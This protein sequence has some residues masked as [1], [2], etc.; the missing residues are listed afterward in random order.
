[1]KRKK[2]ILN[3][4][5]GKGVLPGILCA[6]AFIIVESF[7]ISTAWKIMLDILISIAFCV[8]NVSSTA[9]ILQLVY[10]KTDK[11]GD[12]VKDFKR[13]PTAF[14]LH[15]ILWPLT[16]QTFFTLTLVCAK[17]PMDLFFVLTLWMSC[18]LILLLIALFC[19][20]RIMY[21]RIDDHEYDMEQLQRKYGELKEKVRKYNHKKPCQ[22]KT[23]AQR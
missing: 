18:V 1:M 2:N 6:M 5:L 8:F 9:L 13:A 10:S 21:L 22:Q 14:K 20:I 19:H 23:T 4:W 11:V 15:T 16:I 17:A 12:L 3:Y 7:C